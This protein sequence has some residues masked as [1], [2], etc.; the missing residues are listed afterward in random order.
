MEDTQIKGNSQAATWEK[1]KKGKNGLTEAKL[2][3]Y[4]SINRAVPGREEAAARFIIKNNDRGLSKAH[5][6]TLSCGLFWN[7]AR[8]IKVFRNYE[9]SEQKGGGKR[10]KITDFSDNSRRNLMNKLAEIDARIEPLFTTLTLPDEFYPD[11]KNSKKLQ[12]FKNKFE[13]K[14][15]RKYPEIG[16]I[17]KKEFMPRKSGLYKGVIFPH[18]HLLM[19]GAELDE[20]R[21]WIA[22]NWWEACGKLSADHL[23]AG[24]RT[25]KLRNS[26]QGAMYI[27]K[28]MSKEAKQEDFEIGRVWGV[29]HPENIPFVKAILCQLTEEEAVTLI[30]YMRRFAKMHSRDYK[31]LTLFC[32]ANFWYS[33]LPD[34]LHPK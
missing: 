22:I 19:Y 9:N 21:C 15:N 5:I 30:R 23:A 1:L 6:E 12:Y 18:Y 24:T 17:W 2:Q 3:N 16:A 13:K 29:F 20:L 7:D 25:E 27:T 32:D 28:Y 31:S 10:G 11:R 34:I 8:K 14:L 26:K 33:R 4:Y